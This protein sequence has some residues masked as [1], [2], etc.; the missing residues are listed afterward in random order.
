MGK[1]SAG[2]RMMCVASVSFTRIL[3]AGACITRS[4]DGCFRAISN[5]DTAMPP[6]ECGGGTQPSLAVRPRGI[7]PVG[8]SIGRQDARRPHRL[9]SL[10]SLTGDFFHTLYGPTRTRRKYFGMP[11]MG[12][13]GMA[14]TVPVA[15]NADP[16]TVVHE[17]GFAR[18]VVASR[19]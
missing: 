16:A 8:P 6:D 15:M 17:A 11:V 14:A 13:I 2:W 7:L 5:K 12:L 1:G 4:G 19:L 10:C 3:L 18:S 9:G